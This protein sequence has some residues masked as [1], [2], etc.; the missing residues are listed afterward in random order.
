MRGANHPH[1]LITVDGLDAS[2]VVGGGENSHGVVAFIVGGDHAHGAVVVV[3]QRVGIARTAVWIV[4]AWLLRRATHRRFALQRR[5]MLC[6][7][8]KSAKKCK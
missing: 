1:C 4:N 5:S 2:I 8:N 7:I 3:D 6:V